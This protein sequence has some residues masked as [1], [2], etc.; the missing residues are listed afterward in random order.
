M[1][2]PAYMDKVEDLAKNN[3]EDWGMAKGSLSALR[4]NRKTIPNALHDS[5][6][7]TSVLSH[8]SCTLRL[9]VR[10]DERVGDCAEGMVN[11]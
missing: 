6:C 2:W 3:E 11:S 1:P 4:G 5:G 9:V 8:A 7:G 10:Q